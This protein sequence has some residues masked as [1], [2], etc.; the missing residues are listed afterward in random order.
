MRVAI[1]VEQC[2]HRVPGGTARVTIDLAAALA[3]R[4]DT[5]VVGV[6]ARHRQPPP[7]EWDP[8]IPVR[9][10]RLPRLALYEAWHGL[11]RPVAEA[12]TGPVDV[13]QTT[14]GATPPAHAPLVVTV[15]DLAFRH[16]PDMF[17]RH[18][19]RFFNRALEL[20]RREAAAIMVG[21]RATL[22]DCV[23]AGIERSR[24]HHTPW[25]VEI[26]TVTEADI[27]AAR[28]QVGV[29]G[30]YVVVVGTLEPRKNL[31]RLLDA[32]ALLR[33]DGVVGSS[34]D[35]SLVV[36]GPSGWGDAFGSDDDRQ[37]PEDV[38]LTGFVDRSVRDA[39]YAGAVL[40][41][42][43]SLLEGF[44]LPVLE[45]MAVGCPVVTSSQ[46]ATAELVVDGGGIAVDTADTGTL[47]SAVAG[48]LR[49]PVQRRELA[50]SGPQVAKSY[51]W[52][53]AAARIVDLY[54]EVTR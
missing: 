24:L 3:L 49:D 44:G 39:L 50:D 27:A 7:P 42:Y 15:H 4:S 29:T 16:F 12:V 34:A 54:R 6:A 33:R 9:H 38:I 2:W 36:V 18:G 31:A 13:V 46:T 19:L 51:S 32:W 52:D 45:S 37:P 14:G 8:G 43:P 21:S 41:V 40:S 25:G 30:E 17:T 1:N 26:P 28:R 35:L 5:D 48:L 10:H 47:A 53:S 22:E 11:R 20:A 23:S